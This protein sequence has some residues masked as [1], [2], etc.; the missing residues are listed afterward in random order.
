MNHLLKDDGGKRRAWHLPVALAIARTVF[1]APAIMVVTAA[2]QSAKQQYSAAVASWPRPAGVAHLPVLRFGS[3][4][5]ADPIA[6]VK[7]SS[8]PSW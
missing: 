5:G 3:P 8:R 4:S 7:I 6:K 1:S 2:T